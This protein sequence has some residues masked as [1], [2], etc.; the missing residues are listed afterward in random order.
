MAEFINGVRVRRLDTTDF[1]NALS[2]SEYSIQ[3]A[4]DVLDDALTGAGTSL[5]TTNFDGILSSTDNTVQKAMDTIDDHTHKLNDISNPDGNKTFQMTTREIAFRWSNPSGNP[6]DLE[7]SGAYTG[8]ILHIHQSTGNPGH[9]H[10]LELEAEDNDIHLTKWTH[11]AAANVAL[12]LLV[13][14]DTDT[15]GTGR[16]Q[17]RADGR[18]DWGPGG[19][20]A[21]D[22][23]LYRSAANSLKTDDDFYA[24]NAQF[25]GGTVI[26]GAD[27]VVG[28]ELQVLGDASGAQGGAVWAFTGDAHDDTISYYAFQANED[29]LIIG[30]STDTDAMKLDANKDLYI[31]DGDLRVQ[32]AGTT[33]IELEQDTGT[34]GNI[35]VGVEDTLRGSLALWGHGTG[36]VVGGF[37]TLYVAADHDASIDNWVIAANEDDFF[38]G[39]NTDTDA[40]KLD[41]L[42][43]FYITA[44]DLH[45]EGGSLYLTEIADAQA[46]IAGKGQIWVNTAT[47]NELWFTDDAGTDFQLG[48][49]LAHTH[50]GDTLQADGITS[51]GGE[52]VLQASST[53]R[54]RGTGNNG[55]V[56]EKDGATANF[57]QLTFEDPG[58]GSDVGYIRGYA[59]GHVPLALSLT[60]NTFIGGGGGAC[61]IGGWTAPTGKLDVYGGDIVIADGNVEYLD[62]LDTDHTAAGAISSMTVDANATGVGAALYMVSDGNFD[63]ADADAAATMPVMALALETGTGTKKVLLRGFIRDDTWNWTV[64]GLIYASTT[65]GG[66]TQTAPSGSGD[67]VQVVGIATHADRMYFNPSYVLV[68]I[69]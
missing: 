50:D 66:L 38:I 10:L 49:T 13:S 26:F 4:L 58:Y 24:N 6:L 52:W 23:N 25:L 42:K 2:S 8:A 51:D 17:I 1:D 19:A 32:S 30:P 15:T 56:I 44:G 18:M 7:A 41:A 14:G 16:L 59:S 45:V 63:E 29:D 57:L 22:T 48:V 67:Q 11:A 46:D 55:L 60:A 3:R 62:A 40:L 35:R 43:D 37:I 27:G 20:S 5:T 33:Y 61:T 12:H 36:S 65:T 39:P 31:T 54:I 9:A 47:P 69:A 34:G 53:V 21:V 28:G 68:E 64:G